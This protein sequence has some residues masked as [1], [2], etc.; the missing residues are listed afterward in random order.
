MKKLLL[1]TLLIA[2]KIQIFAQAI[3]ITYPNG[4]ETL[5]ANNGDFIFWTDP[6][7]PTI[8]Q[9]KIEYSIDGGSNWIFILNTTSNFGTGFYQWT[10][11]NVA[12]N[13]CLIKISNAANLAEFDIS[14]ATFEIVAPS[15]TLYYP[16][17]LEYF[18]I[19]GNEEISWYAPGVGLLDII[20]YRWWRK[21]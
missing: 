3:E 2:F 11:P 19:G 5:T 18:A 13:N 21:F 12:S 16:N 9:V 10:V 15:I 17:F 20:L 14:D 8:T 6:G 1:L 4:G 7:A